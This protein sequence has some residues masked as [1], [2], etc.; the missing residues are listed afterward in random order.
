MKLVGASWWCPRYEKF[1]MAKLKHSTSTSLWLMRLMYLYKN[2]VFKATYNN[3]SGFP[4]IEV[5]PK[6]SDFSR[7][8]HYKPSILDTSIC[9]NPLIR[10]SFQGYIRALTASS[11]AFLPHPTLAPS[12]RSWAQLA[13]SVAVSDHTETSFQI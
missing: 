3:K 7:M 11:V 13:V 9:G 8:F 6:S 2:M 5:P 1:G 10:P 4:E 12:V